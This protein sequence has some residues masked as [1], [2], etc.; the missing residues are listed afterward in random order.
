M[1]FFWSIIVISAAAKQLKAGCCLTLLKFVVFRQASKA[2][3]SG[4]KNFWGP[5]TWYPNEF[6]WR[7]SSYRLPHDTRVKFVR[8]EF[9]LSEFIGV[10]L[11][12]ETLLM[13]PSTVFRGSNNGLSS[14]NCCCVRRGFKSTKHQTGWTVDWMECLGRFS[15]AWRV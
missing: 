4:N 6:C 9:F 3:F 10:S 7:T 14:R 15:H 8:N 1:Y 11:Q 12:N 13:N 5:F 2:W